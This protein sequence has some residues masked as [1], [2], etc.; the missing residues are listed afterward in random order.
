MPELECITTEID[1][2]YVTPDGNKYPSITHVLS[3]LSDE[4]IQAWKERIGL[5]K[6]E[7]IAKK[8]A[9]RGTELHEI[10]ESFIKNEELVFSLDPKN[11]VRLMFNRIRRTIASKLD[12]IIA[13]EVPLYSDELKIAG[14]CDCI[15]EYDGILSII[16]FKGA[17]K[18]K[19]K[20]W[21]TSYFLQTVGYS[22]M[23]EERTG[24]KIDQVVILMTG[25]DDFSSQIFVEKKQPCYIEQLKDTIKLFNTK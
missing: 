12:N 4:A 2:F 8:A 23:F 24:I 19:K 5:E 6:A 17:T 22:L 13:Q 25:E 14:R 9:D 20:D 15:A 7:T 3:V 11:K 21:I 18:A 10:L 16:D 1:R